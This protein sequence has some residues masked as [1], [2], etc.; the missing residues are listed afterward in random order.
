MK[1]LYLITLIAPFLSQQAHSEST[2]CSTTSPSAHTTP[3]YLFA[4]SVLGTEIPIGAQPSGRTSTSTS[5]RTVTIQPTASE[6]VSDFEK[7]IEGKP[8]TSP[9]AHATPYLLKARSPLESEVPLEADPSGTTSSSSTTA[10]LESSTGD[11]PSNIDSLNEGEPS[12]SNSSS[13]TT[14]MHLPVSTSSVVLGDSDSAN[15]NGTEYP[16]M[17]ASASALAASSSYNTSYMTSGGSS[18][19]RTVGLLAVGTGA[20][21]VAGLMLG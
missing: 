16:A 1:I 7:V 19:N 18:L 15:L 10:T 21:M 14:T 3:H 5:T 9:S 11:S 2:S 4:K 6:L 17:A 13:P 12:I 8:S 20:L